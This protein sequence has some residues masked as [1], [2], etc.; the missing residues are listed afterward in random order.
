MADYKNV[1]VATN[2]TMSTTVR[3]FADMLH[4]ENAVLSEF[5]FWLF[6]K[7]YVDYIKS[8]KN[9]LVTAEKG[10]I[11]CMNVLMQ[12]YPKIGDKYGELYT[13][14]T[15]ELEIINVNWLFRLLSKYTNV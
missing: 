10:A 4:G 9:C 8:R 14:N 6:P 15:G 5:C 2:K 12:M 3:R 7:F 11:R 1:Y 13:I